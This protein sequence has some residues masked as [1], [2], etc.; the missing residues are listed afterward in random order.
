MN[1]IFKLTLLSWF[2][3]LLCACDQGP[4]SSFTI[5]GKLDTV[6]VD[7]SNEEISDSTEEPTDWGQA[8]I[9][10]T[11]EITNAVGETEIV[12]LIAGTFV[13]GEVT[14]NGNIEHP[15]EVKISIAAEGADPLTLDAVVAPEASLSFLLVEYP[16]F[17]SAHLEFFGA[18]RKVMHP[19]NTFSISGDL[20]S[21]DADLERA[22]LRVTAWEYNNIGEQQTLNFGRVFLDD[23]KFV[24]EADVDEPRLVN[25]LV[26]VP[27]SQ[28]HTQFHAI[29]E[30]GVEIEIMAQSSWLSDLTPISRSGKHAQLVESWQQSEEYLEI[31]QEYRVAYQEY[32]DKLQNGEDLTETDEEETP[33]Y[34]ELSKKLNRIRYDY[35]E[36]VASNAEDPMDALLA[37]EL[38]AYR[39]KEEALPIY[40]RLSNSLD[41]DLVTRRVTHDRN[42]HAAHLESVGINRSL[43]VG[44]Q[45]PDFTLPNLDGEQIS[46]NDLQ[47]KSEFVLV[48]FWASWCGPCIES[49]P[50]LKDL[51]TS[52]HESGFEIVSISVDDHHDAW[53]EGSEEYE[54]PWV[55][56]GELK[57]FR[58]D[59]AT[60]YG[61]TF[62]PKSYLLD[63]EGQIVQKDLS[64][65][66]LDEWLAETFGD[67]SD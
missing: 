6:V 26:I 10:V 45:A 52:Y 51:Y 13:D 66:K 61:V 64:P 18:S 47:Q 3:L 17:N 2:T 56:L 53:A 12:E 22:T 30:P 25:I 38:S 16:A 50:A 33:K 19:A 49:I 37:L 39:G 40:D 48:D 14:M 42:F 54:L 58:G 4:S 35:L 5:T 8:K 57:G 43:V 34:R 20:S 7:D 29:I 60:S 27:T 62:I 11:Q 67:V 36:D 15:M 21:I 24:I 59:I 28:Q 44:K 23:G 31:E 55:N 9:V 32:Q 65:E 46:L 1:T 63:H 41:K